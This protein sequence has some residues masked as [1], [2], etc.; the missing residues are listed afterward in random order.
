MPAALTPEKFVEVVPE[1]ET[2]LPRVPAN[3]KLSELLHP[4]HL[5]QECVLAWNNLET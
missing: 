1:K 3:L 5:A 4:N 2:N